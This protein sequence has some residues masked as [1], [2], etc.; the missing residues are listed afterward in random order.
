MHKEDLQPA[1]DILQELMVSRLLGNVPS[2]RLGLWDA[3]VYGSKDQYWPENAGRPVTDEIEAEILKKADLG[4]W[5]FYGAFCGFFFVTLASPAEL[6]CAADGP[7]EL[8]SAQWKVVQSKFAGIRD[9]RFQLREDV[10]ENSYLH[11]RAA[12][13][14]G[15]PT[16]RE[17][18][19]H[20]VRTARSAA[21]SAISAL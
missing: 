21:Q 7:D 14:A 10:P 19:W 16:F 5:V 8:T 4:A 6:T 3:A 18:A 2:L 1:V 17:L 9:V 15:V 12:V 13:F 20:Q 11:D